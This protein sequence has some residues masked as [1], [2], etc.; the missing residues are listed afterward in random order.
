MKDTVEK[1]ALELTIQIFKV[2]EFDH[3]KM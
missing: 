1:L 3:F 2:G